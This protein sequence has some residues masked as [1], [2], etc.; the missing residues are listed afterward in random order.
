M[1][2]T[3]LVRLT[4]CGRDDG[5]HGPV[6]YEEAEAF[7]EAYLSGVG[8]GEPGGHQR[9]AIIE[10]APATVRAEAKLG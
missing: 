8:V 3:Y 7:R 6:S 2:A 1:G 5:T 9:S 4:C 10:A